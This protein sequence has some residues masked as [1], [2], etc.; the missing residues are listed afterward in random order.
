MTR[1]FRGAATAIAASACIALIA[2]CSGGQA[3]SASST[4]DGAS[5]PSGPITMTMWD[6]ATTD[7]GKAWSE[8]VIKQFE[9]THEG[10]TV[11]IQHVQNEDFD[12]KLQTALNA[13]E[14]PDVFMQ[15]GGGKMR[16]MAAA[17]QLLD[18]MGTA[19]DTPE[20]REALGEAYF[21]A[22]T[23][24]GK[25]WAAPQ[26]FQPD[27]IWYSK[28]LFEQAGITDTPKTVD[29]LYDAI[30]KLKAAGIAPIALGGKDAWPAGHWFYLFALR[31]CS[32]E[33]MAAVQ[34]YDF[35]DPCW[36]K[37]GQDVADLAAKEPF[38]EGFLS[39]SAQ[40]GATSSAGL[41]ANHK[42]AMELMGS[43]EAGV[44]A[45]LTPDGQP[46]ADLGWFPFP[47]VEGGQG[48]PG[49]L[50]GG[51]GGGGGFSCS[52]NAPKDLCADLLGLMNSAE[53]QIGFYKAFKTIPLHKG[54]KSAV[55]EEYNIQQLDAIAEATYVSDFLDT[56]LGQNVGN[57]LN[58]AVV[59]LL[60]GNTDAEGVVKAMSDA[61]AKG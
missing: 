52:A 53:N 15:R 8:N 17:G 38:N 20:L 27:G 47:T 19:A 18:L 35:S 16:D 22:N 40:Q 11:E 49:A 10:V 56:L 7:E 5:A 31:E 51:G 6:N 42:A 32:P 14:A 57:A 34:D 44:V 29:D 13:N 4:T 37:A 23:V 24:D 59:E 48:E 2:G 46:L 25:L 58:I 12:G 26:L 54:A 30:D 61:A 28:D 3:P 33:A 45:S 1:K 39:T 50:M 43:W 41:I 36:V 9:E 60:A 21:E 55:T